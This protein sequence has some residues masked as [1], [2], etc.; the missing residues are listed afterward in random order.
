MCCLKVSG[1]P[2]FVTSFVC[3]WGP[4]YLER[5]N[6]TP[7]PTS[8]SSSLDSFNVVHN[9]PPLTSLLLFHPFHLSPT[10]HPIKTYPTSPSPRNDSTIN[11]FI[12]SSTP[13]STTCSKGLEVGLLFV[14]DSVRGQT[15]QTTR[16]S[17]V[18]SVLSPSLSPVSPL[19]RPVT[20][21]R[22][23]TSYL[24]GHPTSKSDV[25]LYRFISF[26]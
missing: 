19:L 11:S 20:P 16:H 3:F 26:K 17:S 10:P 25:N 12:F 23:E 5:K 4:K 24:S 8:V 18:T 21:E 1:G 13:S 14:P 22:P 7:H 9:P 15:K 2:H 6:N